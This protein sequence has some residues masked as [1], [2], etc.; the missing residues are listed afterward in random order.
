MLQPL[1]V[2]KGDTLD[3]EAKK[4]YQ[5]L[6]ETQKE[7]EKHVSTFLENALCSDPVEPLYCVIAEPDYQVMLFSVISQTHNIIIVDHLCCAGFPRVS[8]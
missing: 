4:K 8:F 3:L 1:M 7:G 6:V 5:S 2:Y